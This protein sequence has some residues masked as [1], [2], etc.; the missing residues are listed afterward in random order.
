MIGEPRQRGV[1]DGLAA[2]VVD[3][4]SAAAGAEVGG[5]STL[6]QTTSPS[7]S[8]RVVM[9]PNLMVSPP[10]W[11]ALRVSRKVTTTHDAGNAINVNLEILVAIPTDGASC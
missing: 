9:A 11:V 1:G 4:P 7:L 10:G 5:A 8:N 3:E 2:A 6:K